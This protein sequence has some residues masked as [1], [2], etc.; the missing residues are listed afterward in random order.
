MRIYLW[1]YDNIEKKPQNNIK[2]IIIKNNSNY[3]VNNINKKN[4]SQDRVI[5]T[6]YIKDNKKFI[7]IDNKNMNLRKSKRRKIPIPSIKILNNVNN[8]NTNIIHNF[9]KNNSYRRDRSKNLT[10]FNLSNIVLNTNNDSKIKFSENNIYQSPLFKYNINKN[11]FYIIKEKANS[12]RY[13]IMNINNALKNQKS[14]NNSYNNYISKNIKNNN[15]NNKINFVNNKKNYNKIYY[16][17]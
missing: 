6:N 15:N 3:Y 12:Q 14:L 11:D 17:E 8:I 5:K 9:Q 1:I 7:N 13:N 16:K 2:V 10:D 4:S